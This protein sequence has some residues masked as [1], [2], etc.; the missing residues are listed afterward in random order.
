MSMTSG[1]S[2]MLCKKGPPTV[3]TAPS[4]H[5]R[6]SLHS[7][8]VEN[9]IIL[10]DGHDSPI[11]HVA[12]SFPPVLSDE[13]HLVFNIIFDP[14]IC[15]A[16]ESPVVECIVFSTTVQ[17]TVASSPGITAISCF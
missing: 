17:T 5:F 11:V 16:V 7:F 13:V 14:S 10:F 1:H 6:L 2:S 3:T 9:I 12:L 8:T 15:S 4:T